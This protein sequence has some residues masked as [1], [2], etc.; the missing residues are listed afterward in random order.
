MSYMKDSAGTLQPAIYLQ[1]ALGTSAAALY[2]S[3][4]MFGRKE[5]VQMKRAGFEKTHDG[6]GRADYVADLNVEMRMI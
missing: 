5:Y 2:L 6:G 3:L 4:G 1:F